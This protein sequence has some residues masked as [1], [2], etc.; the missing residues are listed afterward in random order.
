MTTNSNNWGKETMETTIMNKEAMMSLWEREISQETKLWDM[1]TSI[2]TKINCKSTTSPTETKTNT[3]IWMREIGKTKIK[4]IKI[5]E[6][7][8]NVESDRDLPMISI[9]SGLLTNTRGK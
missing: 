1:K 2:R 9:S 7:W 8:T 4:M 5:D 3:H 6:I